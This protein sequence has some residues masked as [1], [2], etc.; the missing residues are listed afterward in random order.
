MSS[1]LSTAAMIGSFH[2]KL[3]EICDEL[4]QGGVDVERLIGVTDEIKKLCPALLCAMTDLLKANPEFELR[5]RVMEGTNDI[6]V[7]YAHQFE[8]TMRL[9]KLI[10]GKIPDL[11]KEQEMIFGLEAIYSELKSRPLEGR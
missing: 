9:G 5:I 4:K 6:T 3:T 7:E 2:R 1:N 10:N 11:A 8:R